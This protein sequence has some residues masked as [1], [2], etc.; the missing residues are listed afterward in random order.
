MGPQVR[1]KPLGWGSQLTHCTPGRGNPGQPQPRNPVWEAG[2]Y[3]LAPL[4]RSPSWAQQD[5]MQSVPGLERK[6]SATRDHTWAITQ[7]G[8]A[9][10]WSYLCFWHMWCGTQ[11]GVRLI[12]S[13][14]GLNAENEPH[15]LHYT[16]YCPDT[17]SSNI[18]WR[19]VR[20]AES[21]APPQPAG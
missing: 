15:Q 9:E 20:N 10:S 6:W 18:T 1:Q 17:S 3:K 7:K 2:P 14:W 4:A 19:L 5:R 21:Q 8:W 13:S 11:T 12:L 16:K